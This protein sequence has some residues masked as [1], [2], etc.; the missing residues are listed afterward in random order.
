MR[1]RSQTGRTGIVESQ[2]EGRTVIFAH[3][4][5]ERVVEP[6][7]HVFYPDDG[8]LPLVLATLDGYEVME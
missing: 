7:D 5:V 2:R 4:G 6:W 1:Y 3:P 8:L